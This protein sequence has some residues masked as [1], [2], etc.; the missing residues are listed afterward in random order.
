MIFARAN[1]MTEPG[2][3]PYAGLSAVGIG[4]TLP[5]APTPHWLCF[6]RAHSDR[7]A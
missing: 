1:T 4:D 7:L 3:V 6:Q 2:A 5:T